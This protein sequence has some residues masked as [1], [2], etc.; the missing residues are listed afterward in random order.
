MKRT[1]G[2]KRDISTLRSDAGVSIGAAIDA[3]WKNDVD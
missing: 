3:D 1:N 2:S